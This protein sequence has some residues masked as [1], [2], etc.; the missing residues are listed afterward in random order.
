MLREAVRSNR[1]FVLEREVLLRRCTYRK[2]EPLTYILRNHVIKILTDQTFREIYNRQMPLY[3]SKGHIFDQEAS[4]VWSALAAYQYQTST[5]F[6]LC[7]LF[8]RLEVEM[9]SEILKKIHS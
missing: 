7:F 2:L 3:F 8:D 9:P 4:C 5:N 6:N 1:T